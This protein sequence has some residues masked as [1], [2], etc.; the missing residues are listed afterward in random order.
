M[1]FKNFGI[2]ALIESINKRQQKNKHNGSIKRK[3]R[4]F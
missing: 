1:N 3:Q 4:I 2:H